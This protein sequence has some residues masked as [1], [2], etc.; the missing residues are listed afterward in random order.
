MC[1]DRTRSTVNGAPRNREPLRDRRR[2]ARRGH[3]PATAT[4][5]LGGRVRHSVRA[6]TRFS[7]PRVVAA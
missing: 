2:R 5:P 7:I 6:P 1:A 4:G 3:A